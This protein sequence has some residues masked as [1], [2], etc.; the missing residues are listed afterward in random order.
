MSFGEFAA[1]EPGYTS[2]ILPFSYDAQGRRSFDP[3]G[4]GL[5]ANLVKG[6]WDAVR[7]PGDVMQEVFTGQPPQGYAP[8][9]DPNTGRPSAGFLDRTTNLASMINLTSPAN[10]AARPNMLVPPS[11]TR[12]KAT[13]GQQ[14]NDIRATGATIDPTAVGN[15]AG[16]LRTSLQ[17]EGYIPGTAAQ[18]GN[19]PL[20][21]GLIDYIEQN[22]S[23]DIGRIMAWRSRLMDIA[24]DPKN[25]T[26]ATAAAI[27][28]RHIDNSIP[29]LQT[30]DIVGGTATGPELAA[31]LDRARGNYAAGQRANAISGEL[32]RHTSGIVGQAEANAAA[33]STSGNV[34]N[35]IQQRVNAFLKDPQNVTGLSD[36]E[37]AMLRDV[38]DGTA[39][40]QTLRSVGN[41]FSGGGNKGQA[42]LASTGGALGYLTSWLA[43]IDPGAG[44]ALGVGVPTGLGSISRLLENALARRGITAADE[45]LRMRSPLY[46]E[47]LARQ[48]PATAMTG[49]DAAVLHGLLPTLMGPRP[50]PWTPADQG[51]I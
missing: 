43:G 44:V 51:F 13:G 14:L 26:D 7:L 28:V 29:A 31:G 21:H 5:P 40:Q 8:T 30:K 15:S 16:L 18:G 45:A 10:I 50:R 32:D 33:S 41:F 12:L 42:G 19:A 3:L 11:A 9:L 38:R 22:P 37:L 17:N 47:R 4:A 39:S 46:Q 2:S 27:A 20:T 1:P 35:K 48:S 36:S 6:A 24:V 25:P 49:R 23:G 34:G